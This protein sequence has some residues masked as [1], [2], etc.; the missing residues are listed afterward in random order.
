M[1]II[2]GEYGEFFCKRKNLNVVVRL[3]II[4]VAVMSLLKQLM[5]KH[6]VYAHATENCNSV[7]VKARDWI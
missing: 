3:F 1:I 5:L 4:G 7:L 2:S 6:L